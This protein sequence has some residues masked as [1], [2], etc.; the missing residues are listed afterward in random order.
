MTKKLALLIPLG[1]ILTVLVV[2]L[3]V[4]GLLADG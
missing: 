2:Y 1:L 4:G 3:L